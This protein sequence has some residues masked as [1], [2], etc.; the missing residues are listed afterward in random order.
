M[1]PTRLPLPAL[2]CPHPRTSFRYQHNHFTSSSAHILIPKGH[3]FRLSNPPP[4]LPR[5]AL[6]S[7]QSLKPNF[8]LVLAH[9]RHSHPSTQASCPAARRHYGRPRANML[10]PLLHHLPA[11]ILLYLTHYHPVLIPTRPPCQ[12]HSH[13]FWFAFAHTM[14]NLETALP[15]L[16]QRRFRGLQSLQCRHP[17]PPSKAVRPLLLNPRV[18]NF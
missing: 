13:F 4:L 3:S 15:P 9:T 1:P 6:L 2:C 10:S 7:P 12:S 8:A 5:S 18:A 17:V 16:I 11:I 14:H